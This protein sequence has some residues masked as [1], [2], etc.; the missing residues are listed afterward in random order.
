MHHTDTH[1]AAVGAA[2]LA[3]GF[4]PR[5]VLAGLAFY[6]RRRRLAHP[7]GQWDQAGRWWAQERTPAVEEART[8]SRA[9]PLTQN[10]AARTAAHCADVWQAP[11]LLYV[12]RIARARAALDS[13]TDAHQAMLRALGIKPPP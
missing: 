4:D 6:D 1:H 13:P 11:R 8:P 9:H 3:A 5:E 7:P 2:A 12:K 10:Q